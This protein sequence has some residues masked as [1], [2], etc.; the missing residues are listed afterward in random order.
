M[1]TTVLSTTSPDLSTVT[2]LAAG[3]PALLRKAGRAM[4]TWQEAAKKAHLAAVMGYTLPRNVRCD[5]WNPIETL[6]AD[7]DYH[8]AKEGVIAALDDPTPIV[9]SSVKVPPPMSM[10]PPPSRISPPAS[11][12]TS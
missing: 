8:G 4:A 11:R 2:A 5:S 3:V 6:N 12:V 1:S 9:A 7:P 10:A